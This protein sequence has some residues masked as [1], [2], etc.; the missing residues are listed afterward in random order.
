MDWTALPAGH[1]VGDRYEIL[2]GIGRGRSSAVYAARDEATGSEVAL[3]ILDPFLAR[4]AINLERFRREVEII[5]S[6]DHAH[7]IKLYDFFRDGDLWAISMEWVDGTDAAAWLAARGPLSVARFLE[8]APKLLAAVDACHRRGVLHRDIKPQNL[9]VDRHGEIRLV[10][11]GISKVN[12]MSDLTKTGTAI[13]SPTYMAPELFRS[14]RADPRSDVYGLGAVMYE[15][16][17]G[18][19]PYPGDTLERIMTLQLEGEIESLS[20]RR[21]DV[22]TWLA[23]ILEKCLRTDPEARYQSVAEILTEFERAERALCVYEARNER[24]ICLRCRAERMPG[25]GFCWDCGQLSRDV[26]A[27]GTRSV[28]VY[29]NDAP[30]LLA[31]R[32][33]KT[34][35]ETDRER[36]RA[37]LG[38]GCTL[39]C[40]GISEESATRIYNELAALFCEISIVNSLPR[41]LRVPGWL[42]LL[43]MGVFAALYAAIGLQLPLY[44]AGPW[45][46]GVA[47]AASQATILGV[48][49]WRA[50]PLV[51]WRASSGGA[52]T[53]SAFA[54]EALD[55]VR[56]LRVRDLRRLLGHVSAQLSAIEDAAG[57]QSPLAG[58]ARDVARQC[59]RAAA[60]L[61]GCELYLAERSLMGIN[62]QLDA[63]KIKLRHAANDVCEALVD[64]KVALEQELE[65]FYE[66]QDLHA[67]TYLSL[68]NA[69]G[70]LERLRSALQ[71]GETRPDLEG[72][73]RA[74]RERLSPQAPAARKGDL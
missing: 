9:L 25:L 3:K 18:Q 4:D 30:E 62:D 36:A 1:R 13:G 40:R 35:P 64:Q 31:D 8:V 73:L 11:F 27:P 41:Q 2:R 7:V 28:V 5:R 20:E 39:V 54:I 67:R 74:V 63:V 15:L 72:E 29:K 50:R 22:P 21:P 23:A 32:I 44:S 33:A 43:G 19:P 53:P 46:A 58:D 47:L 6:L 17:A 70:T 61:E 56:A 10:D 42:V 24:T 38:S 37:R 45:V 59:F 51:S 57:A 55:A 48:Y 60:Q 12:T 16:L 66:I 68:L 14:A 65:E 34:F 26:L 49:R 71:C 69:N 52:S